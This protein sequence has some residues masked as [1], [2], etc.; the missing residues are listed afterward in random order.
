MPG[1]RGRIPH[2]ANRGQSNDWFSVRNVSSSEAEIDIYG[3]IGGFSWWDDDDTVSASSFRKELKKLDDKDLVTVHINSPGGSVFEGLAIYNALKQHPSTI[4]VVVD[5]LAASAASFI[6]MAADEGQLVMAR[7]AIM[8]IHDASGAGWGNAAEMRELADVLDMHSDNIADIYAQRSGED[9]VFWRTAMVAETWYTGTE[10]VD[11]GLADSVLEDADEK[12]K[13]AAAKF[14]LSIFNYAGREQAPAPSAIH[15]RIKAQMIKAKEAA[16]TAPNAHGDGT[17]TPPAEDAESNPPAPP[18]PAGGQA[19]GEPVG[20][21]APEPSEPTE[22]AGS[23]GDGQ[24]LPGT[25]PP[26]PDNRAGMVGVVVNGQTYQVP[27][28]VAQRVT[29]L[30]TAAAEAITTGR[31]NFVAQLAT[32]NKISAGQVGELEEFVATLNDSQWASWSRSWNAAPTLSLLEKHGGSGSSGTSTAEATADASERSKLEG[33]VKH[34][35]QSGMPE[36]QVEKTPS[37]IKL[38]QLN[39]T[40]PTT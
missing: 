7:N 11:A 17:G 6:A 39:A 24:P 37:F 36:D 28:V 27:A 16:V 3:E 23:T 12:A 38:Q 21:P 9:K 33:I 29:V 2:A 40:N 20:D 30:E 15:Q 10:A 34:H 5:A 8:M 25:Q 19:E 26:S 18:P 31:K 22:E 14:D 35:R 13:E 4:K 1:P 32:N